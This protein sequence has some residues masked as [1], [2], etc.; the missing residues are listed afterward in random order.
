MIIRSLNLIPS[1][2][3]GLRGGSRRLLGRAEGGEIDHE[4]HATQ[5]EGYAVNLVTRLHTRGEK[6]GLAGQ[7]LHLQ[8]A[9]TP[10]GGLEGREEPAK[11]HEAS[12]DRNS[13]PAP[14]GGVG[15]SPHIL[16]EV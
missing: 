11:R 16:V 15:C 13:W 7:R 2:I 14:W 9:H 1:S 4:Q 8:V 5:L 3:G 6:L 10:E 12:A